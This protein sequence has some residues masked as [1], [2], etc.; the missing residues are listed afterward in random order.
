MPNPAVSKS[1]TR[2]AAGRV[3]WTGDAGA[4]APAPAVVQATRTEIGR[5]RSSMRLSAWT[6]TSTSVARRSS[7]RE[8]N[9]SPITVPARLRT[10]HLQ[11][12]R[13]AAK[14]RVVRH[15]QIEPEQADDGADQALCLAPGQAKHGPDRECRQDRQGRIPGLPARARARRRPASMASSVNQTVRLPRW[16]KLAS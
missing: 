15:G 4:V 9:P 5:P 10:W 11:R 14:G 1:L 3:A 12:L 6:A 16:R 7:V 2:S 8:H 13:P